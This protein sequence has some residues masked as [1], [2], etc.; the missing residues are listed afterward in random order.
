M[1]TNSSDPLFEAHEHALDEPCPK[2]GGKLE[3]RFGKHGPFMGCTQYPQCDYIRPLQQHDGHIVKE[4]DMPCP[5]CGEGLVLRQGRYG[6]FIGCIDWPQCT[7]Q[8]SPDKKAEETTLRCPQCRKGKLV[9]RQ[10]RYGKTFYACDCYPK[11]K[12]AVNAKPIKGSCEQCGFGLLLEKKVA[13]GIKR[14]CADKRCNH[15][16]SS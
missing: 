16:Q 7:Y 15:T 14:V 3:F 5:E 9:E 11:C 4:L 1:T 10:S 13:A 6:M 12:F 8:A 2:C